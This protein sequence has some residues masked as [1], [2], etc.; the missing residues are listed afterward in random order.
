MYQ[1]KVETCQIDVLEEKLNFYQNCGWEIFQVVPTLKFEN[2]NV[3]MTSVSLPK[4][5]EY[6]IVMRKPIS[7][8]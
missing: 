1:W 2:T 8:G 3:V 5:I 6:N 4:Q 7:Q